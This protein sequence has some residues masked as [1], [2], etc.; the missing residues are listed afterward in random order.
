MLKV[1]PLI[2][3][4]V[5]FLAFSNTTADVSTLPQQNGYRAL[6][7]I[8]NATG[9]QC[10]GEFR[11]LDSY[12]VKDTYRTRNLNI[13]F[14]N[15]RVQ[16][17][18]GKERLARVATRVETQTQVTDHNDR[19]SRLSRSTSLPDVRRE[20]IIRKALVDVVRSIGQETQRRT[21]LGETRNEK[22]R[23]LDGRRTEENRR[24]DRHLKRQQDMRVDDNRRE[25]QLYRNEGLDARRRVEAADRRENT[26]VYKEVQ[27]TSWPFSSFVQSAIGVL[28]LYYFGLNNKSVK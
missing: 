8:S 9:G 15:R 23:I 25:R 10:A 16:T 12:Y 21:V 19:S 18:D 1:L 6:T 20:R 24:V 27:T 3:G 13:R 17:R 22:S 28:G 14:E 11:P 4:F 26:F 7:M 2:V 5:L